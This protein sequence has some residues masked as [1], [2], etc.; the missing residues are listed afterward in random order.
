[1]KHTKLVFALLAFATTLLAAD[2]FVGTWKMIPEKAKAKEGK[3]PKEQTIV[4]TESGKDLSLKVTG[5][6]SDGSPT[7]LAFTFPVAGGE[8]KVIQA[9]GYDGVA[10]KVHSAKERETMFKKGG[11]TVYTVH[12]KIAGDGMSLV[13]NGKGINPIGQKVEIE[14]FYEKQK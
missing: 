9:S 1:M 3:A 14:M 6:A 12:T 13:T 11:Q 2:P 7:M 5:V 4:A 8:G 10:S